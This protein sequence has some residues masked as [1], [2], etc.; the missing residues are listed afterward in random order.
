MKKLAIIGA[1]LAVSLLVAAPAM[2]DAF[3][4]GHIITSYEKI[5]GPHPSPYFNAFKKFGH[6]L[7]NMGTAPIEI[8]KQ[9]VVEAEK[10]ESVGEFLAGLVYGA[11]FAG[12]S[13]MIYRELDGIYA[14]TTFYCPSWE[15]TINPEYIF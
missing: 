7:I 12:P 13:W 11:A 14:V 4:G 3:I 2:A 9:P 15:T 5:I 6:G 8:I 1:L 10:G